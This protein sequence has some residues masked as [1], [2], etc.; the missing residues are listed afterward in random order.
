MPTW[1]VL[2]SV[3]SALLEPFKDFFL[4]F[5]YL[6]W[7]PF[8]Y[9]RILANTLKIWH[10]WPKMNQQKVPHD[11]LMFTSCRSLQFNMQDLSQV[12]SSYLVVQRVCTELHGA[13]YHGLSW[14]SVE[15]RFVSE[16]DE[17]SHI[18]DNLSLL[19]LFEVID[20]DVRQPHALDEISTPHDCSIRTPLRRGLVHNE[21]TLVPFQIEVKFKRHRKSDIINLADLENPD[22]YVDFQGPLRG[23]N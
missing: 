14:H 6:H 18:C 15:N 8:I 20:L 23:G 21:P 16:D 1:H 11:I 10:F 9:F 2:Y 7:W 19:E 5:P 22:V 17:S 13:G 12:K 3:E 4:N